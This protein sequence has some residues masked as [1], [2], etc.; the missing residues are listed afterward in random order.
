MRLISSSSVGPFSVSQSWPV[1]GSKQSPNEFRIPSAKVGL[2]G[3]SGLS[4]GTE[5]S[6]FSRRIRPPIPFGSCER[7]PSWPSPTET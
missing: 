5:P 3:P 6:G 2:P 7:V 1:A 4:S